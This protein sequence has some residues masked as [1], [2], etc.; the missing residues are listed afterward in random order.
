M[1]HKEPVISQ[2]TGGQEYTSSVPCNASATIQCTQSYKK[3]G[4]AGI[5]DAAHVSHDTER[6]QVRPSLFQFT[7][8]EKG[9]SAQVGTGGVG[10]VYIQTQQ[11]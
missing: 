10:Q 6:Q 8:L 11:I 5:S 4:T 9:H 1:F 7:A 3:P 2:N